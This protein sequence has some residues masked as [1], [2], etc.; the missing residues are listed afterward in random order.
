VALLGPILARPRDDESGA[1]ARM[2]L[3]ETSKL[4]EHR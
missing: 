4:Q 3:G 1:R 2:L